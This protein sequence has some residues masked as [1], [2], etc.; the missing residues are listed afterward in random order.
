LKLRQWYSIAGLSLALV[1]AP[2]AGSVAFAFLEGTAWIFIFGDDRW[3]PGAQW[4][5]AALSIAVG[6]AASVLAFRV[7]RKYGRTREGIEPQ[8]AEKAKAL[9]YAAFPLFLLALAGTE[10]WFKVEQ[11]EIEFNR[12]T[13]KEA[14]F[15]A[16]AGAKHQ[17]AAVDVA[18]QGEGIQAAVRLSGMRE[19]DYRLSWRMVPSTVRLPILAESRAVRLT[20]G[21]HQE[22]LDFTMADLVK[23]YQDTVLKG[24]RG[25]LVDENFL[26]DVSLD[27]VLT[28]QERADLPPGE[29]SRL[30]TTD[31]ALHSENTVPVPVRFTI[32]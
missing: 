16:L 23:R 29:P 26:L 25:V 27:P 17:I 12:A 4:V 30:G 22:R 10:M 14:A 13:A 11:Q 15:A 32:P 31:S 24:G 6:L 18:A 9:I 20:A 2:T 7:L 5:V 1:A 21:D 8:D 3:P 19:G 28:Q